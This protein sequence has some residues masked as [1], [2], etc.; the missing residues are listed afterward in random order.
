MG[1]DEVDT[2]TPEQ[3][4]YPRASCG[5]R[6]GRF[7][8]KNRSP[9]AC[10]PRCSARGRPRWARPPP[11]R[12]GSWLEPVRRAQRGPHPRGGGIYRFLRGARRR[13]Q[14][15]GLQQT[16]G[17]PAGPQGVG[18]AAAGVRS[19]AGALLLPLCLRSGEEPDSFA[20]A[21]GV[22][23]PVTA[24]Q[25]VLRA[26]RSGKGWGREEPG[27]AHTHW[28]THTSPVQSP[29]EVNSC[30]AKPVSVHPG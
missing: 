19:P 18:A 22:L 14:R 20:G 1:F 28:R 17:L 12:R 2:N 4:S 5:V 21:T 16:R 10:G 24:P 25:V 7:P 29:P 27:S 6:R 13:L 3:A 26:R 23:G 9:A 8:L 11:A 30:D 15:G